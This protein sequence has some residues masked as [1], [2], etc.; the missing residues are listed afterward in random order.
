M[1]T[2]H[3]WL[4]DTTGESDRQQVTIVSVTPELITYHPYGGGFQCKR[5]NRDHIVIEYVDSFAPD[6]EWGWFGIDEPEFKGV[7]NKNQNWNG[8]KCPSFD[9]QESGQIA[10]KLLTKGELEFQWVDDLLVIKDT[11]HFEDGEP[12]TVIAPNDL[13]NDGRQFYPIGAAEWCWS[14]WTE[15][16]A[17]SFLIW[18]IPMIKLG[19]TND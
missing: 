9:R 13:F 10:K 12:P 11:Y 5:P 8:W 19:D 16:E 3:A 18:R 6:Y 1:K 7:H 17:N 4:Y 14:F 15:E 2:K